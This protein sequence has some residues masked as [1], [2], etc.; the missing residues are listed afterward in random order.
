MNVDFAGDFQPLHS[1]KAGQVFSFRL[2]GPLGLAMKISRKDVDDPADIL[3]LAR[4]DKPYFEPLVVSVTPRPQSVLVH[5]TAI[6]ML[7]SLPA[8]L[9]DEVSN[10][11]PGEVLV[12]GN[13]RLICVQNDERN[14]YA[15]VLIDILS[16]T[17]SG[18]S[19]KE[20]TA[21]F[22]QWRIVVKRGEAADLLLSYVPAKPGA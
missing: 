16:G 11:S 13:K 19:T 10:A 9:R 4:S 15:P 14:E 7:E 17:L 22:R 1:V 20:A 2:D 18:A 6:L 5:S 3:L 21:I 12:T 8:V